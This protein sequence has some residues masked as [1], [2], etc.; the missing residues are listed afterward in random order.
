MPK[1]GLDDEQSQYA[2]SSFKTSV[3]DRRQLKPAVTSC[4][5]GFAS[6]PV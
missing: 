3:P 2:R 4:E 5:V 1:A 6:L